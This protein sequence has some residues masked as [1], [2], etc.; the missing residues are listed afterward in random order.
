VAAP[1]HAIRL[2]FI[3]NGEDY[4]VD[5]NINAALISSVERALSISGN[6]GRRDPAE[7]ELRDSNGVMLE[8]HRSPKDFGLGDGAR[9]FLSLRVGAGG[10]PSG[11]CA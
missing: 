4:A 1:D 7:W 11:A 8:M 6:T 2:V 3:I 5:T 9:L 10:A